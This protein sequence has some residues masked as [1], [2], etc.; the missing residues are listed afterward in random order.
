MNER[1]LI[2][3][4][5]TRRVKSQAIFHILKVGDSTLFNKKNCY[6]GGPNWRERYSMCRDPW[7]GGSTGRVQHMALYLEVYSKAWSK[8]LYSCTV[9][10]LCRHGHYHRGD[11]VC[12]VKEIVQWEK[13]TDRQIVEH[14]KENNI[15]KRARLYKRVNCMGGRTI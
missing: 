9:E 5:T 10:G 11:S 4:E 15:F 8:S 1:I 14:K 3:F 2:K 12:T 7:T 6:R 13:C